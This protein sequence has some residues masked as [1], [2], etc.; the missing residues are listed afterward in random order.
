M[1]Y[2]LLTEVPRRRGPHV[3]QHSSERLVARRLLLRM[4][5]HHL[6]SRMNVLL[7][8]GLDTRRGCLHALVQIG[9]TI[10]AAHPL[11]WSASANSRPTSATVTT[12]VLD[13]EGSQLPCYEP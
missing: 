10:R 3:P 5:A 7:G 8:R 4:T 12:G 13:Q 9:V 2:R 6:A 11:S 1:S